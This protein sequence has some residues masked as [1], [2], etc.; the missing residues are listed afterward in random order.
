MYETLSKVCRE[1]KVCSSSTCLLSLICTILWTPQGAH[2][3]SV[4]GEQRLTFSRSAN[5]FITDVHEATGRTLNMQKRRISPIK[6]DN[7]LWSQVHPSVSLA[8][9]LQIICKV[10]NRF[11]ISKS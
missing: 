4:L 9:V 3:E 11:A 6:W 7:V 8:F 2:P 10:L 1:L 5:P